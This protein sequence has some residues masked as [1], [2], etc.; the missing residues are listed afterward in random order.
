MM[1]RLATRYARGHSRMYVGRLFLSHMSTRLRDQGVRGRHIPVSR[2]AR[3]RSPALRRGF[4]RRLK[5][6]L[7]DG[8][9][10]P[11]RR[12]RRRRSPSGSFLVCLFG[13]WLS[14]SRIFVRFAA[15]PSLWGVCGYRRRRSTREPCATSDGPVTGNVVSFLSANAGGGLGST[16]ARVLG[17][18]PLVRAMLLRRPGTSTRRQL[19]EEAKVALRSS[20]APASARL[21]RRRLCARPRRRPA[22]FRRATTTMCR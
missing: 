18:P 17:P 13:S 16:A 12:R 10:S 9:T 7:S 20:V 4:G 1:D 8:A 15:F 22:A 3:A 5:P 21:Y 19:H 14:R 11:R 2:L 6:A